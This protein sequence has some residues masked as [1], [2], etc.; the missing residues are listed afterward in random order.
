M[1]D[2]PEHFEH[3]GLQIVAKHLLVVLSHVNDAKQ[4]VQPA[5]A[6]GSQVVPWEAEEQAK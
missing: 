2:G 3:T 4:A 5:L 6:L 1:L